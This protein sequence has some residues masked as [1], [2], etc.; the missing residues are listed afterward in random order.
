MARFAVSPSLIARYYFHECD[1]HLRYAAVPKRHRVAEQVP[2]KELDRSLVTRA[3]LD[4]GYQWEEMVIRDRLAPGTV[5]IADAAEDATALHDRTLG[6]GETLDALAAAQPGQSIY[7]PTLTAPPSFYDAYGLDPDLVAFADCR[8]DLLRFGAGASPLEVSVVDVKASEVQKLSHRIQVGLYT[9]ILRHVIDDA[10]MGDRLSVSDRGGVWLFEHDE[11]EPFDLTEIL[12]PLETFLANELTPLL[13]RPAPEAFWHLTYRCES[14]DYYAHCRSQAEACDD[15]SLVP[16]LSTFAKRHLL[17]VGVDTVERLDRLL[18]SPRVAETLAGCASLE[19]RTDRWKAAVDALRS[20]TE[21]TTGAA[22]VGMPKGENVVVVASLQSEPLS[23]SLY[24]Y[25]LMRGKGAHL[26]G[27]GRDTVARVAPAGDPATLAELRRDLVR[28]LVAI[29]RPVHDHNVAHADSWRDQMSVQAYVF[30]TFERD[31]LVRTLLDTVVADAES[32]PSTAADA[33]S[34]LFHFQHPELAGADD[35]P[36][37]T[38]FF[39]VVVLTEAVRTLLALPVPV[40]YRFAD[41]VASLQPSEWGFTY[42]PAPYWNFALSNRMKS[43]A[44]LDVWTRGR[45]DLVDNIGAELRRRAFATNSVIAGLR[46]RLDS[47][48]LFAWPPKF[49]MPTGFGMRDPLLSRLAFITQYETVLGCLD[50]RARRALPEPQ[51]MAAGDTVTLVPVDG[52][53]YR[54]E[55]QDPDVLDLRAGGFAQWILTTDTGNGR[56]ARLAFDDFAYR[57]K[58]YAPKHLDLALAS[59]DAV[60]GDELKLVLKPAKSF[61]PP[62][63]G[64]RCHLDRR[65]TDFNSAKVIKAL[66]VLDSLTPSWFARVVADPVSTRVRLDVAPG[67][68]D[69]A[70]GIGADLAMTAS[71]QAALGGTLEHDVQLVWGPPGTGKTHFLAGAVLALYEAHRRSGLPFRALLTGF[72][73]AAIDNLLR[74]VIEIQDRHDIVGEPVRIA[75]AASGATDA[76]LQR[77]D[78]RDQVGWAN[79]APRSVLGT[80]LWQA[81]KVDAVEVSYDLVVI[82][83]GSQLKVGEAAIAIARK[84]AG[85]RLLVAGDDRQL[86]PIVNGD[87]PRPHG[88]PVLHRSILECLRSAGTGADDPL[89]VALVEN[90]R[91]CDTLCAYPAASIYPREYGPATAEIA[92]RR[93]PVPASTGGDGFVDLLL[94]PTRPLVVCVLEDVKAT[95]E[96]AVEA[97][98]VARIAVALRERL[99][100]GDDR[101]FWRDRLFV[102]SPHHAQIRAIRR[103][104]ADLRDW[105]AEPFVG[106]VDKMQ[107]QECDA[108]VVSYGVSD[109]EYALGEKEF[110]FSRNRLNVAITRARAKSIVFLSRALLEPPIQALDS[111]DVAEGI[112]FMQG[113]ARHCEINGERLELDVPGTGKVTVL[114]A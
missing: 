73:H 93:L 35:H 19:Q 47:D 83:E 70:L 3:I 88:E 49:L 90:W 46:E 98:L 1:R 68:R 103:R 62:A 100:D 96:N 110:I 80:T 31:L 41:V 86:P 38:V 52:D 65:H 67:L 36:A 12:P 114:R 94:D 16:Y 85:G 108:V 61:E 64:Q 101:E 18:E 20:G 33:L 95:R 44:I 99:P 11:P 79:A 40:A 56:R 13:D 75:K 53:R 54:I 77:I 72:T 14:C 7:Q 25:A 74:K 92:A 39:P 29:L 2:A 78:P 112:A 50:V 24:G 71:Q 105:S 48:V 27:N 28:D 106:T 15:V 69:V 10:G 45:H 34:L 4:G 76:D 82:D 6:R 63:R 22:S 91:M 59:I 89:T 58:Q 107:G 113:L 32:D 66:R 26:F 109:V 102:V 8:P 87:Y 57:D 55:G 9:L 111:D 43:D 42:D 81:A 104:L 30:D 5:V 60:Q 97:D 84:A 21:R 51:R 17:G 37:E 23:G